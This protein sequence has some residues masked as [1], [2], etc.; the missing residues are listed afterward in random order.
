MHDVH[1]EAH[2]PG[3]RQVGAERPR[4]PAALDQRLNAAEYLL[5]RLVDAL[6]GQLTR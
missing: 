3:H 5:V 1:G 2:Q 4:V 6:G